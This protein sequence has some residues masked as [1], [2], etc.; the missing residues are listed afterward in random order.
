MRAYARSLWK[1]FRKEA[2]RR[3]EDVDARMPPTHPM[4]RLL[5]AIQRRAPRFSIVAGALG[6]IQEVILAGVRSGDFVL[7]SPPPPPIPPV[8]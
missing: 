4:R 7:A 1:W 3:R 6:L 8:H 2:R 5:G